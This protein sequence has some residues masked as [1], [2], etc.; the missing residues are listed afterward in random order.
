MMRLP[1]GA[2]LRLDGAI[3]PVTVTVALLVT[4]PTAALTVPLPGVEPAV[5]VVEAPVDGETE[6]PVT[7]VDQAASGTPTGFA[8]TSVPVAVNACV[9]PTFT[10]AL[11]GEM[12]IAARAAAFTLSVWLALVVPEAVAGKV[13]LPA[14][15]SR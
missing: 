2:A 13:G 8:Y 3:S 1:S 10:V 14:P 15:V 9:P 5:K 4:V 6:P 11:P 12:L 7:L